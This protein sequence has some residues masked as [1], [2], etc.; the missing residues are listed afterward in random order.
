MPINEDACRLSM[1]SILREHSMESILR[2][3]S[4][5]SILR[6]HSME[7]ILRE[8][9]MESILRE[10]SMESILREHSMESILREHSTHLASAYVRRYR[11]PQ[12]IPRAVKYSKYTHML[13]HRVGQR[14]G[15]AFS[16]V[17][18]VIS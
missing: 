10:H 12:V 15:Q 16:K 7:S 8:H 3:H 9:S 13:E 4:T 17:G 2:E 6:E 18:R 5:E 11:S 1:E 14:A